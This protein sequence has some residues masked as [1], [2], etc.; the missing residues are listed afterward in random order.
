[1]PENL[2]AIL[3]QRRRFLGFLKRR[4]RDSD[5][6]EDIL[7]SAY[8][9]A[10]ESQSRGSAPETAESAVAWFYRILR[11]A[12]IDRYRHEGSA[13]AAIEV[14]AAPETMPQP[15]TRDPHDPEIYK[16]ACRC[17][18]AVLPGLRPGYA[19]VL[20][21]VE[22]DEQPLAKFAREHGISPGNASVRLHRARAALK[23]A[24]VRTC[25]S[26]SLHGCVDCSCVRSHVRREHAAQAADRQPAS[27]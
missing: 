14:Q 26:C 21:E 24:M 13:A 23:K 9:R 7:Q 22:L 25:G 1:M 15:A 2:Q 3:D 19:D 11:N 20:R 5:A 17:I 6:A 16:V 4:V 18:E 12:V 10:L 8:L 27:R